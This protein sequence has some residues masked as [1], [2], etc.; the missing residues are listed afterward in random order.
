MLLSRHNSSNFWINAFLL[1]FLLGRKCF[2]ISLH[3]ISKSVQVAFI[4]FIRYFVFQENIPTFTKEIDQLVL[5]IQEGIIHEIGSVSAHV[6]AIEF[7]RYPDFNFTDSCFVIIDQV[8]LFRF[9]MIHHIPEMNVTMKK[10]FFC[11]TYA[12]FNEGLEYSDKLFGIHCTDCGILRSNRLAHVIHKNEY[13][14]L[15]LNWIDRIHTL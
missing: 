1:T 2:F 6:E 13:G 9:F 8:K 15:N 7:V 5:G 12:I 3:E 10:I 14:I 4:L 11:N